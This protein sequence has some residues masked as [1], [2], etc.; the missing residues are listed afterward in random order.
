MT[1]VELTCDTSSSSMI[2]NLCNVFTRFIKGIILFLTLCLMA[3]ADKNKAN[4]AVYTVIH[5]IKIFRLFPFTYCIVSTTSFQER[6]GYTCQTHIPAILSRITRG[7]RN[8]RI[9][10]TSLRRGI[11]WVHSER[12]RQAPLFQNRRRAY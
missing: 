2:V 9:K 11:E 7:G 6:C 12:R 10:Y 5:H 1:N 3:K 4:K 8:T